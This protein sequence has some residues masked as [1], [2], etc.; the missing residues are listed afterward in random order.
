MV[1]I[2]PVY[3]GVKRQW[4]DHQ[5]STGRD[6]G[7]AHCL[8]AN[9]IWLGRGR[10]THRWMS[11][12]RAVITVPELKGPDFVTVQVTALSTTGAQLGG[13]TTTVLSHLLEPNG[14]GSGPTNWFADLTASKD[15]LA[16]TPS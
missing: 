1:F 16:Y 5:V 14:P 15:G 3:S 9:V 4:L 10:R 2:V 8:G 6:R 12:R 7:P 13:G 11:F